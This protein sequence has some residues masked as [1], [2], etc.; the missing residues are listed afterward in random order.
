VAHRL[1]RRPNALVLLDE[2]MSCEAI[3]R[4]LVLDD[5]TIRTWHRLHR[6]EGIEGLASFAYDGSTCLS[7][8]LQNKLKT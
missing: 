5:D 3:A 2:G 8:V 7:D 4:V 1:A 6:A